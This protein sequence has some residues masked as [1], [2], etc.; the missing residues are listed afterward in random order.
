MASNQAMKKKN[1][2]WFEHPASGPGERSIFMKSAFHLSYTGA[3]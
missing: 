3:F 1:S 2:G